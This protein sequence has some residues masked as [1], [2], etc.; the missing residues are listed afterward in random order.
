MTFGLATLT[1]DEQV[2]LHTGAAGF[3]CV[4]SKTFDQS[5]IYFNNL[6]KEDIIVE[7]ST[8]ASTN[9]GVGSILGYIGGSSVLLFRNAGRIL[10]FRRNDLIKTTESFS[11]FGLEVY[12][13]TGALQYTSNRIPLRFKR[14]G[15]AGPAGSIFFYNFM[16]GRENGRRID[17]L[18]ITV[19]I[20]GEWMLD[21]Y[22]TPNPK[23]YTK[24]DISGIPLN[25]SLDGVTVPSIPW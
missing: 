16:Y 23:Y 13:E 4:F 7:C 10:V 25:F 8:T 14:E 9:R 12:G 6:L 15:D 11:N 24:V 2:Q 17:L 19:N 20:N 22:T 1:P 21:K 18:N 5:Y 3:S